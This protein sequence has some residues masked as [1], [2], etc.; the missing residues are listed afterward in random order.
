MINQTNS[1]ET[2]ELERV[3]RAVAT[4]KYDALQRLKENKDFQLV[5]LNGYLKDSAV[6]KVSLLSTDYIRQ[7][8][9]RGALFEELVAISAF[10]GYMHMIDQLG[11]PYEDEDDAEDIT[12]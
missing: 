1:T 3:E 5:V 9:L 6:D 8:N 2:V 7:N 11:A 10:E 12:E 4:A